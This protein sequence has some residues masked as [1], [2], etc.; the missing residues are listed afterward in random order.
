MLTGSCLCGDISYRIS[1]TPTGAAACHCSQCRKQS[2]HYW[3]AA[4]VPL[5]E[6]D[7]TGTPSWYQASETARRGFCP[8][9]GSSLFWQ[10]IGNE[11]IDVSLGSMDAPTGLHLERHIYVKDKGD[12]YVIPENEEQD[13][14]E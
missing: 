1:A 6:I 11:N 13:S 7:I 10:L 8:R 9:C 3:A 14:T 4:I 2:G 12:Y 5:T